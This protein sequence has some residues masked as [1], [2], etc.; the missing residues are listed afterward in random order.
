[1]LRIECKAVPG[2][3]MIRIFVMIRGRR[4]MGVLESL[5][6]QKM[7]GVTRLGEFSPIGRLFSLGIFYENYR[8]S[9]IFGLLVFPRKSYVHMY[10]FW[11]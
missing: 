7:C 9:P 4:M 11:Q 3:S 1:L 8:R 6:L 10:K 2:N 5:T